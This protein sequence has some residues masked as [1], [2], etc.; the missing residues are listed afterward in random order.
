[1]YFDFRRNDVL[2]YLYTEAKKV[3]AELALTVDGDV[4]EVFKK[5]HSM[6][7]T[8]DSYIKG[9]NICIEA[10]DNITLIVG[11]SSISIEA[12]GIVIKT[13]SDIELDAGA[14]IDMKSGA[15]TKIDAGANANIKSGANT[16]IKAGGMADLKAGGIASVKGS[17]VNIN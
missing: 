2:F 3:A 9:T 17:M 16:E 4:A 15:D 5:N 7:V 1:M 12:D 14:K 6:Q 11:G 10:T 13:G 8:D